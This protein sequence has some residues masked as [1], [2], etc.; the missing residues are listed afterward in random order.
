MEPQKVLGPHEPSKSEFSQNYLTLVLF[1]PPEALVPP[2]IVPLRGT[3]GAWARKNAFRIVITPPL[4]LE[5]AKVIRLTYYV[6][7][8]ITGGLVGEGPP[9]STFET[10]PD[11]LK[12]TMKG[13]TKASG[14][15]KSTNVR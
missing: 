13:G 7:G 3:S 9:K 6:R 11:P 2:F 1:R 10:S 8:A 14:D 15:L 5:S 4:D 12:G